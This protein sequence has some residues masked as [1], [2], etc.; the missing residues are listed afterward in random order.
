MFVGTIYVNLLSNWKEPMIHRIVLKYMKERMI[1]KLV[2]K[3]MVKYKVIVLHMMSV[4]LTKTSWYHQKQCKWICQLLLNFS[5]QLVWSSSKTSKV[6]FCT[7]GFIHSGL[8]AVR[9]LLFILYWTTANR[10]R[11]RKLR[12]S[13]LYCSSYLQSLTE[14]YLPQKPHLC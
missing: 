10:S 6:V 13:I 9:R 14:R 2:E 1:L 11:P 7:I 4:L 3:F 12:K 8:S 5:G